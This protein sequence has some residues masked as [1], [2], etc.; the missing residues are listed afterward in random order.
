MYEIIQGSNLP[1]TFDIVH[2]VDI[3]SIRITLWHCRSKLKTWEKDDVEIDLENKVLTAPLTQKETL[4]FPAGEAT[5]EVKWM[6]SEGIVHLSD[7]CTICICPRQD[8]KEVGD[9]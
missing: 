3:K 4:R 5:V 7:V 8:S 6:D 1:L 2:E 9:Q